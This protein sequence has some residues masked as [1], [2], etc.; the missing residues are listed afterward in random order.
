MPKNVRRIKANGDM[1]YVAIEDLTQTEK[2]RA[3]AYGVGILT[4]FWPDPKEIVIAIVEKR[5]GWIDD[6]EVLIHRWSHRFEPTLIRSAWIKDKRFAN[7]PEGSFLR[8]ELRIA[9]NSRVYV[10]AVEVCDKDDLPTER[11][12]GNPLVNVFD[13]KAEK[14]AE[15]AAKEVAAKILKNRTVAANQVTAT[16]NIISVNS[17]ITAAAAIEALS[18]GVHEEDII[19]P[20]KKEKNMSDK[21]TPQDKFAGYYID[22]QSRAIFTTAHKMSL[23]TPEKSVNIMIAGPS[24]YGKTTLPWLFAQATGREFLRMNCATIRDPEEW[25]GFREAQAGTTVFVPSTFIQKLQAGNIVVAMDEI[26]RI[27]PWLAN[28]VF[29]LLDHDG[30]TEVHGQ[31]FKVGPNVIIVGT[32]NTGYQY[33]GVFEMDEALMRRFELMIQ[34]KPMPAEEEVKVLVSRTGL[35]DSTSRKIVKVANVLRQTNLPCPTSSTLAMAKMVAAG[36]KVRDAFEFVV[37]QRLPE[38]GGVNRRKQALDVVNAEILAYI[39]S[40]PVDDVFAAPPPEYEEISGTDSADNKSKRARFILKIDGSVEYNAPR[41]MQVLM[42]SLNTVRPVSQKEAKSI[43]DYL[44]QG[45]QVCITV[46][47]K[48]EPFQTVNEDLRQNG[49][50]G[51]FVY[52]TDAEVNTYL[53]VF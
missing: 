41:F 43:S 27:E 45:H 26:N 18:Y 48:P 40:V 35:D 29:P 7:Y 34:V 33:T 47:G 53:G 22:T 51:S 32:I 38:D 1:E 6:K 9:G 15:E 25:F 36:L 10:K 16:G 5:P 28:T 21:K 44:Q 50:T 52:R 49:I 46:K 19:R 2:D 37:V 20:L 8:V 30:K 17:N 24:G 12:K 23:Q 4:T 11:V 13:R 3:E 42:N 14:A 39:P 31:E